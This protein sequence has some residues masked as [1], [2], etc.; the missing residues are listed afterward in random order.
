MTGHI[1]FDKAGKR[2]NYL[3]YLSEINGE[4]HYEVGIIEIMHLIFFVT[5]LLIVIRFVI[6]NRVSVCFMTISISNAFLLLISCL[7]EK[8]IHNVSIVYKVILNGF[9]NIHICNVTHT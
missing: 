6:I 1:E 9:L 7:R 2:T 4:K 5:L 3:I 8:S